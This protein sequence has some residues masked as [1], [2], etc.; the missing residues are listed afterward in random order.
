VVIEQVFPHALRQR[1]VI[2]RLHNAVAKVSVADQG[3]FKS[4]WW[5]VFDRITDPSDERAVA[6]ARR[7]LVGFRVQ[8]ERAHPAAVA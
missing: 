1:H 4:D 3:S 6:E 5:E 8:W 2:H 7:P